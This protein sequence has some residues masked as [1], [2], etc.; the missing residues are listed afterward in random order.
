MLTMPHSLFRLTQKLHGVPHLIAQPLFSN[1][2]TYL[3]TRNVGLMNLPNK[4]IDGG[5]DSESEAD[6]G[7]D[8][9]PDSCGIIEISGPLTYKATGW[10][11]E[12]GGCSYQEILDK[13]EDMIEEGVSSI[14]LWIDSG[15][16]ESYGAFETANDIR[17]LCDDAKVQLI[18]YVDG[19]C[20]SAAYAIACVADEVIS[21]PDSDI[22]SIGVLV[23]FCDYS[24]QMKQ[25]GIK[26]IYISAG[27]NKIPYEDDGSFKPTFIKDLQ[28]KVD[29]LYDDFCLHVS[30]YTGLSVDNVKS[31]EASTY[32]A[33]EALKVGFINKIM[34]RSDFMNYISSN[35]GIQY[36]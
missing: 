25:D 28:T 33:K 5:N 31:T 20:C 14:V 32:S 3:N 26:P 13:A 36:A 17:A 23:S 6:S 9:L 19:C 34:T 11:A 29:I 1:I 16:G 2:L 18:A 30:N 10:E 7:S 24:E 12:C 8:D 21:N 35:T 4:K 15:G 27:K 22:G